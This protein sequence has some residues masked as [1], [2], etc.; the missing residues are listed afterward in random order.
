MPARKTRIIGVSSAIVFLLIVLIRPTPA[1]GTKLKVTIDNSAIRVAP[2]MGSQKLANVALGKILDSEGREGEFYK[3]TLEQNGV[4]ITGFIHKEV[5]EE[6]SENE[7][8]TAANPVDTAKTQEEIAAQLTNKIEGN[9]ELINQ[10]KDLV[11]AAENLR[12]LIAKVFSLE[13]R[14]KQK[15]TAC[16]IYWLLGVAE[17]RL[18][19]SSG[20]I[21]E[22]RNMFEVDY[23]FAKSITRYNPEPAISSLLDNAEKQYKGLVVEY[24]YTISTEPKE[25]TVRIDG[26]VVGSSP[27]VHRTKNPQFTLEIEKEGY[28]A[29]KESVFLT[30]TASEKSY[31]LQ[32]VGRT[33]KVSSSP[34]GAEV[35]LDGKDI[36]KVTECELSYVPYGEHRLKLALE[37]Y[38]DW[39][40]PCQVVEGPGP[41]QISAVMTVENYVQLKKLGGPDGRFLRL[42]RAVAVDR[43]GSIYIADESDFKVR[44]YTPEFGSQIWSD[45]GLTIRKLGLPAGIAFDSQD[46]IYVTDYGNSRV[47]KFDRNGR[48]ISKWGRQG[49]RNGELDAPTGIGIDRNNDIYVADTRNHRVVKYSSVGVFKKSWGKKGT[50][51]GDFYSPTGIA[52]SLNDEIYVVDSGNSR[53]QKF[54]S[55][56]TYLAEFGKQ[57]SDDGELNQPFGL[58]I[59]EDGFIYVADTGNN[60]IQ[61]FTPDGKLV[62]SNWGGTG[63][64]GVLLSNPVGVAV[65]DKRNV[66]IIEKFASRLQKFGVAAKQPER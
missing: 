39:E 54:T 9:K 19:D 48:E 64:S 51:P 36:G 17:A 58:C 1:A 13:D 37:N 28:G 3:V 27:Y 65:N 4:K 33:I 38:A 41:L 50:G 2:S 57:G 5:V 60:R 14:Q 29:V 15:Q 44:K 47:V 22:F 10:E 46:N 49:V 62:P 6:A 61:K 30:E 32:S 53:I 16:D 45:P 26:K 11:Q 12:P 43:S 52:V 35:L 31:S 8:A 42:P 56:G 66:I 63:L 34:Q 23:V 20:A 59:D 24:T 40:A 25:A 55:D 21:R 18:G 7:A